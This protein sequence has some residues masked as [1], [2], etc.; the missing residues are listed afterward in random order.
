MVGAGGRG[1]HRRDFPHIRLVLRLD[2]L[3]LKL[4][5]QHS[6][7]WDPMGVMFDRREFLKRKGIKK[8]GNIPAG[9]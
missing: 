9:I 7:Y 1:G 5:M 6:K 8:Y 2:L 4:H 3:I